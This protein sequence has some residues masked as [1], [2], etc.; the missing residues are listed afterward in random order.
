MISQA[1]GASPTQYQ[2]PPPRDPSFQSHESLPLQPL[3]LSGRGIPRQNGQVY[4]RPRAIRSQTPLSE[5]AQDKIVF[6]GKP[7]IEENR[8]AIYFSQYCLYYI[9]QLDT[10]STHSSF[11]LRTSGLHSQSPLSSMS[12]I[13]ILS[14]IL[15]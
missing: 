6:A 7:C 1:M 2:F 8:W 14:A 5:F 13:Q 10:P 15:R 9:I 4:L 3:G 11:F 12:F